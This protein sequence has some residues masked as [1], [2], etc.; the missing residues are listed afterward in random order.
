MWHKESSEW[1]WEKEGVCTFLMSQRQQFMNVALCWRNKW[2]SVSSFGVTNT[3]L[4]LR[5]PFPAPATLTVHLT[6]FPSFLPDPHTSKPSTSQRLKLF[7]FTSTPARALS[8]IKRQ[9]SALHHCQLRRSIQFK[10]ATKTVAHSSTVRLHD[11]VFLR[12]NAWKVKL[13]AFWGI[14]PTFKL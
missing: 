1:K 9:I 2:Q 8:P 3:N 13:A 11:S 7:N 6:T 10:Q 4:H 14:C 12:M 5:F